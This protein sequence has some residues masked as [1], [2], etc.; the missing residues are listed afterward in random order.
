MKRF[1]ALMLAMVVLVMSVPMEAKAALDEHQGDYVIVLDPGHGGHDNGASGNGIVEK[2]VNLS[3][4]L[5]LRD[6]LTQYDNITVY[7]TR[8]DDTFVGLTDIEGFV[9][10]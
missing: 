5:Y 4:A 3:I 8:T 2:D 6:F 1:L 10:L 7:M 9:S